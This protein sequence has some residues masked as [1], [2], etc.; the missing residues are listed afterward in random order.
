MNQSTIQKRQEIEKISVLS[1]LKKM[2]IVQIACDRSAVSR[3]TFYRWKNEDPVFAKSVEES[4]VEGIALVT[5]LSEAQVVT[6]IREKHW[7]AISF[8][9]RAHHP[10][11]TNKI[12]INATVKNTDPLT[13]EQE[14]L[15]RGAL[16]VLPLEK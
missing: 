13:P 16:G 6:L 14:N 7:N 4:M 8:W 2:P 10:T 1:Q 5:D 9:L 12:N 3:A 15:I 11:Y